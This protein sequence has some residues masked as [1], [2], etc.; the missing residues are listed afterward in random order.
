[1]SF[2]IL[3]G[4]ILLGLI[5]VGAGMAGHL[6]ETDATSGYGASRGVPNAR[7]LTQISG[8]LI[9]AAGL[10]VIFG[11]FADLAALGIAAY[12]L[13]AAF[14]VHHFWTDDDPMT[15]QIEMTNFMKNLSIAGGALILFAFLAA[16]GPSVDFMITDPVFD[17]SL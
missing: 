1:M 13:I 8:V 9:F 16:A 7:L 4:R 3:I 10:G 6:K 5:F 15:Q 2:V 11:V 17:F 14:M 12:A